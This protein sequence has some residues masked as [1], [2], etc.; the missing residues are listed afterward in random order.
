MLAALHLRGTGAR[1]QDASVR[2]GRLRAQCDHPSPDRLAAQ[3]LQPSV[4]PRNHGDG[5]APA[6][7]RPRRQRPPLLLS[8]RP[9]AR[10]A[11]PHA[12]ARAHR[13]PAPRW[14][15][16]A[17]GPPTPPV[18]HALPP[19]RCLP[20]RLEPGPPA[21]CRPLPAGRRPRWPASPG[22]GPSWPGRHSAVRPP[23][24]RDP[25]AAPP[26]LAHPASPALALARHRAGAPPQSSGGLS[27]AAR[28][29][30]GRLPDG[31]TPGRDPPTGRRHPSPA[32]CLR[33]PSA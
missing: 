4:L 14:A 25:R 23:A 9:P 31:P 22:P 11:P 8:T 10:L 7:R 12:P 19:P 13:P 29:G 32:A 5:L 21:P 18:R 16:W 2:A 27:Q 24:R 30:A 26:L 17:S 20:S 15:A 33:P 1:T 3:A 28:Q 6:S